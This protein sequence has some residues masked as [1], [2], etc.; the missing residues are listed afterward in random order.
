M[1]QRMGL[2][3]WMWRFFLFI[4]IF[5]VIAYML[6][7]LKIWSYDFSQFFLRSGSWVEMIFI[8]LVAAAVGMLLHFLATWAYHFEMGGR[9]R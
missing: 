9:R 3:A 8:G 5:M 1:R 7:E 4:I 6:V 2:F